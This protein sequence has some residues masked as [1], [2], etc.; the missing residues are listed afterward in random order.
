MLAHA[1][2]AA[3]AQ[4]VVAA[5]S[6]LALHHAHA[7]RHLA[8][9][10]PVL[11]C[12]RRALLRPHQHDLRTGELHCQGLAGL[13]VAGPRE[14]VPEVGVEAGAAGSGDVTLGGHVTVFAQRRLRLREERHTRD[15]WPSQRTRQG[16]KG[17]L[18]PAQTMRLRGARPPRRTHQC[19]DQGQLPPSAA[20]EAGRPDRAQPRG[21]GVGSLSRYSHV[22]RSTIPRASHRRQ[23]FSLLWRTSC[24]SRPTSARTGIRGLG[25]TREGQATFALHSLAFMTHVTYSECVEIESRSTFFRMP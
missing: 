7:Q 4:R 5:R 1:P 12:V 15:T 19:G 25:L 18:V 13:Q 23:S 8:V 3:Y 10:A 2:V 17:H 22:R 14:G 24:S 21:V 16:S 6:V 9:G 20:G 11:Q